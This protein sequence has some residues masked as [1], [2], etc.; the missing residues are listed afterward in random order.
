[1][2]QFNLLPEVKKEYVKAKRTKRMIM[3]SAVLVSIISVGIVVLLYSVVQLGQKKYIKDMTA[4]IQKTA[5]EIQSTPD[6]NQILT[7]QNQLGL[8]TDLHK[9]KP[10]TS[11]IFDYV[12]FVA[13]K[14]ANIS[15]MDLDMLGTTLKIQGTADS[16]ATV[17]K[18]VE[19]LKAVTYSD[20]TTDTTGTTK[21]PVYTSVTTQLSGDSKSATFSFSMTFD[22][23]IYDNTKEITMYLADQTMTTK[24]E[25]AQ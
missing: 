15:S 23:T 16:I 4:D 3:S 20:V 1:M 9:G 18:Y 24:K 6:L 5:S 14:E 22:K 21:L 11:R 25:E 10:E 13:P 17:N 19:N 8:L 12:S 2:I 7:V